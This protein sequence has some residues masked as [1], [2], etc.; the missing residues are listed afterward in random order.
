MGKLL[1]IIAIVLALA[2]GGGA[3]LFLKPASACAAGADSAAA[4]ATGDDC[5]EDIAVDENEGSEPT[6][7]V[8]L[9]RQFVIP[10]LHNSEV[11]ALVVMSL[12]LEVAVGNAESVYSLEPKLRDAFLQVLFAHAHS[13]GFDGQFT[14]RVAMEDLKDRLNE[15]A[16]PLVGAALKDVL[17]TEIVRQDL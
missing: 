11:A 6:E 12:S 7:F 1:P 9:K 17:I 10:I 5:A 15:V 14:A 8:N 13:G 4:D 2:G 3:G 16:D